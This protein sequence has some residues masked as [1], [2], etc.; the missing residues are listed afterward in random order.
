MRKTRIELG[1]FAGPHRDVVLAEDQPHL[2]RKQAARLQGQREHETSVAALRL[3]ADARVA[4]LGPAD[5]L[6]E[7]DLM[8]SASS[9]SSS[10]LGLRCPVSSRESV[11]FEM[12]VSAASAVKV[13]PRRT[14]SRLSRG[15]TS[16]RTSRIAGGSATAITLLPPR[17]SNEAGAQRR[18]RAVSRT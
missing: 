15:P 7:R 13:T 3:E 8:R 18:A 12:P 1:N 14:R 5:E 6:V 4:D 11:L 16:A 10:R 2:P 17:N 9:S